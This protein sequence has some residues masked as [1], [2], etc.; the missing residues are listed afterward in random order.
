MN[1][2]DIAKMF[3]DLLQVLGAGL[4][5]I[6]FLGLTSVL[7]VALT[8][9]IT[10][11]IHHVTGFSYIISGILNVFVLVALYFIGKIVENN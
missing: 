5:F 1:F 3:V 10:T 2:K 8:F 9:G 7:L 4:G 11:L 6:L